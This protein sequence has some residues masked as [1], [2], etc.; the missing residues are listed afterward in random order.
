MRIKME[1][2]DFKDKLKWMRNTLLENGV[3]DESL[4]TVESHFRQYPTQ[5]L[6]YFEIFIMLTVKDRLERELLENYEKEQPDA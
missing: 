3:E 5:M 6:M 4:Q 1:S 2:I